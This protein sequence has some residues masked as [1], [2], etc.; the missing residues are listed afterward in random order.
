ML[1]PRRKL[2]TT[3]HV[4]VDCALKL[5]QLTADDVLVD[6][7]C[8]DGRA[9][10]AGSEEY[11]CHSIGYEIEAERVSA[12]RKSADSKGLGALVEVVEGNALEAGM[13]LFLFV[14]LP[15]PSL[16]A[17]VCPPISQTSPS[18]LLCSCFS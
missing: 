13:W 9:I 7:G 5:L 11:G 17:T 15:F 14:P 1:A 8:G 6:Y 4:V 12:V 18:P 3:P 10:L 16:S 2:W